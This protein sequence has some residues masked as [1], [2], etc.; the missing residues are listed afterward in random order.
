MY[1]LITIAS[2]VYLYTMKLLTVNT[3]I[4]NPSHFPYNLTTNV[5]DYLF[6]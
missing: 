2:T 6:F 5:F 4:L 1:I 3:H